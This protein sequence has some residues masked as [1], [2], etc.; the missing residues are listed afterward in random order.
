[1]DSYDLIIIGA[2]PAGL[3][4]SIY[5]L[6]RKLR[7]L[8]LEAQSIGGQPLQLYAEK[9]I[10]DFPS[11]P[12]ISG[13]ELAE[14]MNAHAHSF[15][16]TIEIAA[17]NAVKKTD[18]IFQ[19][20]TAPVTYQAHAVILATGMGYFKPKQLGIPGETDLTGKGVF[21]KGLPEKLIGKRVII[22]GGGDT[23]LEMA[24]AAAEKGGSV[25]LVHRHDSFRAVEKTVEKAH[26]L[27]I[28]FYL[29]STVAEILG[30][31]RVESIKIIKGGTAESILTTDYVCICI[32]AEID[33]TFLQGLGVALENQAVKV[34]ADMQTSI[35]G[36]FAAGDVATQAGKY[37]RIS[38]A[39]GTA[40]TA[41]NGVYQFLKNPYWRKQQ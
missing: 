20:N 27:G 11:Y 31:D 25:S 28:Q 16:T 35:P 15:G 21:Y 34:D 4:A 17:V 10:Y 41:V 5:A 33:R 9:K 6:E 7:T 24:V 19:V 23:A 32:G 26:S 29:N 13:R 37:K 30:V 1:M 8:V 18:A 38:V 3:A 14:K 36:M 39:V 12:Q 2:G 40:A 22:V